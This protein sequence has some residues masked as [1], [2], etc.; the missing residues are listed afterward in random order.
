MLVECLSGAMTA[1]AASLEP[2]ENVIR[3]GG[4]VGRQGAFL[5][6]LRPDAFAG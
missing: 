4:A 2:D 6:M 1:T 3:E 5:W